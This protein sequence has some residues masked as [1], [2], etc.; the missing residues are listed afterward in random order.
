MITLGIEGTAHTLGVGVVDSEKK[1]L[2]NV[3]DMYRPPEGGLHPREAA[4][5]HTEVVASTITKAVEEAKIS[6]KDVDL[7]SFSMG[8]GLG[9][10]LRVAATAARSLSSRLNIPIVGVN[11]CIAHIEIGNATT[12][13]HDPAMLYASGGNTQVIAY[14]DGRY[15][16]FGETHDVGIG[17]MLDKLG[18][19]LG[20]GF[21]A[22][23]TIEKLA[24]EGDK[25]LE[26][27]YSVKGMDIAFSG[28]MT[29][30]L[31]LKK[32]GSRLEDIAYSIQETAFAMLTE[33]TERA[34]AHIGKDE[35]LLGGGVAQNKRLQEMVS[36]MAEDRGA[37]MFVPDR[38][39]CI[40]NGAMIAWLGNIMYNSGIR[41]GIG[42]TA[43][44]QRFRTDEV[45]VAWRD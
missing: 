2:S 26:L 6:L 40:D 15:R 36:N 16:I 28:I 4:N 27:P 19:E 10:C 29:A 44:R 45:E 3:I 31:T 13:C 9:P 18:R 17:N 23:P 30:A 24:K 41:M 7:V 21:Y 1:V 22:G 12:G 8:P 37:V 42:D 39:L 20:L 34:M 33:V 35:V 38:R 14:S 43:V 32:K 11:H 25:L 5:H